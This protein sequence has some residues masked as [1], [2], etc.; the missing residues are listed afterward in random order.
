MILGKSQLCAYVLGVLSALT[1]VVIVVCLRS[2][3]AVWA[4]KGGIASAIIASRDALD[5][6]EQ[7][8]NVSG[9]PHIL[10][11]SW[12]NG[13]V[14]KHYSAWRQSWVSNHKHWEIKLW[15]DEDNDALI[16]RYMP[17][18]M[19]RYEEYAEPV[20]KADSVRYLYMHRY[21]A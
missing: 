19:S 21:T 6:A 20:M 10:H 9:I 5:I 15:T 3:S 4:Y 11:Q 12:V 13:S 18:F 8:A 7:R 16:Q 1:V 2:N 14:P 17:W